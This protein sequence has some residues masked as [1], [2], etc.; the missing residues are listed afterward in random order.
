M[1]YRP[2]NS[3]MELFDDFEYYVIF[4]QT[5]NNKILDAGVINLSRN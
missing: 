1:W 4:S 5:S 2:P 3:Q